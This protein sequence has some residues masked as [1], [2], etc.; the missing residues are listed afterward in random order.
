MRLPID[1]VYGTEVVIREEET[2]V[3]ACHA[4]DLIADIISTVTGNEVDGDGDPLDIALD[5]LERLAL[6]INH[7]REKFPELN[8]YLASEYGW[9]SQVMS[10]DE[11]LP[12]PPAPY[13]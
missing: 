3:T 11:D 4:S 12:H 1:Y 7:C 10:R 6:T 9:D 2:F 8:Q 13:E 5:H